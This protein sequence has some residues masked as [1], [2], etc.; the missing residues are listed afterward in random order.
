MDLREILI[1]LP[2]IKASALALLVVGLGIE[3]III[4]SI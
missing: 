2:T 4:I 1:S 3:S